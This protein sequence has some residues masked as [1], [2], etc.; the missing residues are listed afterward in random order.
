MSIEREKLGERMQYIAD[1]LKLPVV[2][3]QS[4]FGRKYGKSATTGR[5]WLTGD[6]LPDYDIATRICNDAKVSYLWL[7]QGVGIRD[8]DQEGIFV[9]DPDQI[10]MIQ[11]TDNLTRE[12]KK[13][14]VMQVDTACQF[15]QQTK[16]NYKDE[17]EIEPNKEN[18][19][20]PKI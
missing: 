1:K 18:N 17:A 13:L 19:K 7:T 8:L 20:K 4:A 6:K 16:P 14:A 5:N 10:K 9:T 15:I 11:L 12:E 2:G 3:R